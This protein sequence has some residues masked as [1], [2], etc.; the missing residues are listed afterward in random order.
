MG[1]LDQDISALPAGLGGGG[2]LE[3]EGQLRHGVTVVGCAAGRLPPRG[4][5]CRIPECVSAVGVELQGHIGWAL[6][7]GNGGFFVDEGEDLLGTG[8]VATGIRGRVLQ[9]VGPIGLYASAGHGEA[10]DGQVH[11]SAIVRGRDEPGVHQRVDVAGPV[12]AG[13]GHE[14]AHRNQGRRGHVLHVDDLNGLA[15]I[16]GAVRG[17]DVALDREGVRA[18]LGD[19]IVDVADDRSVIAIVRGGDRGRIE[20]G[21]AAF[22]RQVLRM[23]RDHRG[24][25]VLPLEELDVLG[26]VATGVRGRQGPL[27]DPRSRT[28]VLDEE[29][30]GRGDLH[31]AAGV[32]GLS[33]AV[34]IGCR[35]A[36]ACQGAIGRNECEDGWDIV[37]QLDD[38]RGG[39]GVATGVHG[40]VQ[41]LEC[42]G[43]AAAQLAE[44]LYGHAVQQ[45]IIG[46]RHETGGERLLS[47]EAIQPIGTGVLHCRIG[48][49]HGGRVVLH[50]DGLCT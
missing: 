3:R 28:S 38:L 5:R 33:L 46:G 32:L 31:T 16:A 24:L 37:V 14:D 47:A 4:V 29:L 21:Q 50:L 19:C 49:Q 9:G 11:V 1:P 34:H 27:P 6:D 23:G 13:Q 15:D 2:I 7:G 22:H 18:G 45:A 43:T 25:R 36:V 39:G 44:N 40:G 12:R 8:R 41:H 48:G 20:R 10:V 30:V 35:I 42:A 26:S 17:Q